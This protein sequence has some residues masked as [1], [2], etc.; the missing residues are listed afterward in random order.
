[1][2][3]VFALWS[4]RGQQT[5]ERVQKT[6]SCRPLRGM[7]RRF[8][9]EG[10]LVLSALAGL[11]CGSEDADDRESECSPEAQTGCDASQV[12]EHVDD[13]TTAC[14]APFLIRGRVVESAQTSVGIGGA[15][16]VARD[17]NGAL[18]S[19]G[20]A[21]SES[22]GV[23]ELSIP[24]TRRADG[25]PHP[26]EL[27]LRADA[28]GYHSF[29]SGLR[30]A[31]PVDSQAPVQSGERWVIENPSTDVA[32]D[33]LSDSALLGTIR[34][35]VRAEDA[36]GTLV[37]AGAQSGLAD[38]DG[39]FTIFNVPGGAR[40][41]RGYKAG[42]ALSSAEATVS[43][44]SVTDG[45]E[46]RFIDEPL[47]TVTGDV[48]F[49]NAESHETSVVLVVASTFNSALAR[50]EVPIGLRQSPVTGSYAFEGVPS[51]D[52]IVLAAFEDD[53]LVRDPDTS[54][55]GT[56]IQSVSVA[57][58]TVPVDAFKITGALE[59][60]GPGASGAEPVAGNPVFR[61][62][63]DS[64]EDGYELT[65]FDTFGTTVFHD[66][67]VPSVSGSAEVSYQYAGT[68]LEPG[69]YQFRAVSFRIGKG[70]RDDRTRI[71]ATEDLKGVF[72]AP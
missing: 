34:G 46:L 11:A 7:E 22:D 64:S 71:S 24:A 61:W 19:R 58:T 50:G 35:F 17:I 6:L 54:I 63:D 32:L 20:V 2:G 49:V 56:A 25:S 36:A 47:G 21:S 1:M 67:D 51:G 3:S 48:N 26:L 13:G 57:G 62:A 9:L 31:V 68:P 8:R 41:V 43:E 29:P 16:V 23:Y 53:E 4:T 69:Y 28:K 18:A 37:V 42:L 60:V 72:I 59:V 44:G 33:E 10:L 5:A 55:G 30:I 52:Y 65:V 27:T 14:F 15:L 39:A 40:E 45:V 38:R 12:C 70:G 66:D